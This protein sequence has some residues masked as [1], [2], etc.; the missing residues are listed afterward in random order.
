M[1]NEQGNEP[2]KPWEWSILKSA[3]ENAVMGAFG[4]GYSARQ[5]GEA[6]IKDSQIK[7]QNVTLRVYEALS[8]KDTLYQAKVK[9][10]E[11]KLWYYQSYLDGEH[12]TMPEIIAKLKKYS[13]VVEAARVRAAYKCNDTCAFQLK[14]E[15]GC[16][17]GHLKLVEA[18]N[19]IGE[20]D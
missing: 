18:L 10:L 5:D 3:L 19:N 2:S 15:Y 20:Q 6:S 17:C 1:T 13:A 14:G 7:L 16:S 4:D 9:A 11:D 12:G 8:A